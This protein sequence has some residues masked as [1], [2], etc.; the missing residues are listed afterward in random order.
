MSKYKLLLRSEVR[1]VLSTVPMFK[2]WEP[3]KLDILA[4]SAVCKSFTS[5]FEIVKEGDPVQHLY[6]VKRG[7]ISLIK[8]MEKPQVAQFNLADLSNPETAAKVEAPGLWVLD[9]NWRDRMTFDKAKASEGTQQQICEFTVG[10][11]GSGQVFG[12]L[13]ILD[14]ELLSPVSAISFTAV[15]VYC[16]DSETL[17][18]LGA[19]FVSTCINSLNESMNLHN[20]PAEKTYYYFRANYG[21]EGRKLKL[22]ENITRENPKLLPLLDAKRQP[23]QS[24]AHELEEL[25]GKK[26]YY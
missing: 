11:L 19:R 1:L 9:K 8:S 25:L 22:M 4:A 23:P 5:S 6:I 16:F 7:I 17:L 12:E 2:D 24:A 18:S 20:P 3:A 13:A 10:V 21:W 15:E 14:P 26:R